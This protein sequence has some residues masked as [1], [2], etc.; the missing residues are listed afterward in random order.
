MDSVGPFLVL[1]DKVQ[2]LSL[3][4]FLPRYSSSS[5][6]P[7][8]CLLVLGA[9]CGDGK[10]RARKCSETQSQTNPCSTYASPVRAECNYMSRGD[11]Q[12]TFCEAESLP[13]SCQTR[14]TYGV[15]ETVATKSACGCGRVHECIYA[16]LS[17]CHTNKKQQAGN[18]CITKT[19]KRLGWGLQ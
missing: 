5:E 10:H 8:K 18:K 3:T 12:K 17:T 15:G 4:R 2:M 1:L 7:V 13:R 6:I 11:L 9:P 14:A 19:R 16:H